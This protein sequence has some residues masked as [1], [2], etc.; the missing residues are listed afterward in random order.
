V[1]LR[2]VPFELGPVHFVGVGGIGMSAI[3]E[4]MLTTG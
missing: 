3:A 2:P 4:I 1:K